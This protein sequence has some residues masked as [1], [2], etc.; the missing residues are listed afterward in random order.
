[1]SL[2]KALYL[3]Y[4]DIYIVYLPSLVEDSCTERTLVKYFR[5]MALS[6]PQLRVC[7]ARGPL[8]GVGHAFYARPTYPKANR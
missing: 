3:V 1:M 7:G 5:C 4:I 6:G 8:C 2:I